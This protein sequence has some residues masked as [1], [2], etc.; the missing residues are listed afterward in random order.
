MLALSL[1]NLLALHVVIG[2]PLLFAPGPGGHGASLDQRQRALCSPLAALLPMGVVH[3]LCGSLWWVPALM[4]VVLVIPLMSA[5][6]MVYFKKDENDRLQLW[7]WSTVL[8][9]FAGVMF[10][11]LAFAPWG[12]D[13]RTAGD[14]GGGLAWS[15][16]WGCSTE[17]GLS[18]TCVTSATATRPW[19]ATIACAPTGC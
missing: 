12:M 8:S 7:N 17:S 2:L 3:L 9:F 11:V 4:I 1:R 18:S 5:F 10:F 19:R 14:P 6:W 16:G 15:V 13:E